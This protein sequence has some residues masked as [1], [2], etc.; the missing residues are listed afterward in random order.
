MTEQ[1]L[2]G[3]CSV[4]GLPL[5]ILENFSQ[6]LHRDEDVKNSVAITEA[7]ADCASK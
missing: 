4:G 3:G 5:G 2:D 7:R 6:T 1:Q